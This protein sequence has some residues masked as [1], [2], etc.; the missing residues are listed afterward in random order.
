MAIKRPS[1]DMPSFAEMRKRLSPKAEFLGRS[2]EPAAPEEAKP[3][4]EP[5][6][7]TPVVERAPEPARAA[8]SPVKAKAPAM[9][10]DP[11]VKS[12]PAPAGQ[13]APKLRRAAPATPKPARKPAKAAA[14]PGATEILKGR[15]QFPASGHSRKFD[16]AVQAYG[17]KEAL[18]LFLKAALTEY[19]AALSAGKITEALDDYPRGQG[20]LNV[21]RAIDAEA[22]A[23]AREILDPMEMMGA[24]TLAARIMRNA[25]AW[26]LSQG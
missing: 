25:L 17:E 12:R 6:P 10:A 2:A 3:A 13:G 14:E 23:R 22:F 4:P 8:P 19:A 20:D 5:T 15:V 18:Q 26:R 16:A 7:A 1:Q 21:S 24:A 11:T 9:P